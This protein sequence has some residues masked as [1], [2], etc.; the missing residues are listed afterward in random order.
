MTKR[1]VNKTQE[2]LKTVLL[3]AKVLVAV[4]TIATMALNVREAD[5]TTTYDDKLAEVIFAG[6]ELGNL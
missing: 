4:A 1:P 6:E 5:S 2:A 3:I